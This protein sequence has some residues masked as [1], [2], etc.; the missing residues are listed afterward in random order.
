[1]LATSR[2][3]RSR[4]RSPPRYWILAGRILRSRRRSAQRYRI[5]AGRIL[6]SR[7]RSLRQLRIPA[8]GILR[9][10]R[11]EFSSA[12]HR[13][14]RQGCEMARFLMKT[15]TIILSDKRKQ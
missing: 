2:I 4:R 14:A 13:L 10:R 11:R 5:A 6:R 3:L 15:L 9:S 8:G 7:R 12:S 1:M